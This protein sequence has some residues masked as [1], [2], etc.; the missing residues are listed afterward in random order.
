M[1]RDIATD[2]QPG[3]S[4]YSRHFGGGCVLAVKKRGIRKPW[5]DAVWLSLSWDEPQA[6]RSRPRRTWALST[7]T[8]FVNRERQ[9]PTDAPCI[10]G[11]HEFVKYCLRC[12]ES[13]EFIGHYGGDDPDCP[14]EWAHVCIVCGAIQ[15]TPEPR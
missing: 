5:G 1:S 4:F 3:D 7:W 12:D 9:R 6:G 10:G 11:D 8:D 13:A 2:P 15:E 14:H